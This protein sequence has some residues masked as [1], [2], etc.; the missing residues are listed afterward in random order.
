MDTETIVRSILTLM[1]FSMM[2]VVGFD[3]V[4]KMTSPGLL[5]DKKLFPDHA[6]DS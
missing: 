4:R 3:L 1:L 5:L 2:L 6:E